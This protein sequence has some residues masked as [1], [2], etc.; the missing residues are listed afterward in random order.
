M[1]NN[2][3]IS[4][5]KKVGKNETVELSLY[6]DSRFCKD[7][8]RYALKKIQCLLL[9][10]SEIHLSFEGKNDRFYLS[11]F[12]SRTDSNG[13][14]M[15]DYG[16]IAGLDSFPMLF[17]TLGCEL[18][19]SINHLYEN[20]Q[21]YYDIEDMPESVI[22]INKVFAEIEEGK[23]QNLLTPLIKNKNLLPPLVGYGAKI[24]DRFK[25]HRIALL[26]ITV[27]ICCFIGTPFTVGADTSI[28]TII[29]FSVGVP[30]L[31][32]GLSNFQNASVAKS[33]YDQMESHNRTKQE[34]KIIRVSLNLV[35][36]HIYEIESHNF[37]SNIWGRV[38][39]PSESTS[40][41]R[42]LIFRSR[43]DSN[44]E[45]SP[46]PAFKSLTRGISF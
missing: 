38:S 27:G 28:G 40:K 45:E 21:N 9:E 26:L 17:A 4:F 24:R 39:S 35:N 18:H 29:L 19:Q 11:G 5:I 12:I 8:K 37:V 15:L 33:H 13:L 46:R 22:K 1:Q 32:A 20:L 34:G 44:K 3:V 31:Y 30:A 2:Q 16:A 42:S 10:L 36:E 25:T 43:N 7:L 14:N 41:I 23:Q 6:K